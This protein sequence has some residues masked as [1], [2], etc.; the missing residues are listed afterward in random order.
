MEMEPGRVVAAGERWGTAGG[1]PGPDP[2]GILVGIEWLCALSVVS[3]TET[4]TR[5]ETASV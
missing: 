2:E 1:S 5:H 3:V 4:S